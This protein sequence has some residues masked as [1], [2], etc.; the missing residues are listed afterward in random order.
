VLGSAAAPRVGLAL[1]AGARLEAGD[2]HQA[3][4]V[5]GEALDLLHQV[6]IGVAEEGHGD[7]GAAGAA[8]AADAVDVTCP[9]I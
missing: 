6:P 3:H 5:A 9:P 7:A 8:G 2:F 4:L 1:A